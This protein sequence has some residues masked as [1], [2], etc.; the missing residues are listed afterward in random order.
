M[1]YYETIT[2]EMRNIGEIIFNN[3]DS[4]YYL[5]GGTALSL[6]IGHR[7][8]IDLDYF[9]NDDID[10]LK[11]KNTISD[12]FKDLKVEF[13]FE[14][15]NTLWCMINGVKISFVSRFDTLLEEVLV[16]DDFRLVQ[17][18]DLTIMKLS[19]ICGREEYKDYFDLACIS[20]ITDVR[21]WYKWWQ[22]VYKNND[23]ISFMIALANVDYI[24]EIPLNIE[25]KFKAIST[26]NVLH[27]TVA[28]IKNF[29]L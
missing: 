22:E 1:I 19:A 17:I 26:K 25:N 20:T 29:L 21:L 6:Q 23:P 7:K 28:E 14:E 18:N 3:F 2:E 27:R 13:I 15:K 10:T 11:L 12:T 9:I 24:Q 8:S 16:I 5:A 4:K